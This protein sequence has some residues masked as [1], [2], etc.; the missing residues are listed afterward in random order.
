[1]DKIICWSAVIGFWL[2]LLSI[3]SCSGGS[4]DYVDLEPSYP[5]DAVVRS[6]DV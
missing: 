1:M 2:F 5:D 4:A 3:A 6:S